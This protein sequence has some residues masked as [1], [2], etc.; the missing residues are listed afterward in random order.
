MNLLG[1]PTVEFCEK[2]GL[3]LIKRPFYALSNLAYLFVGLLILN[4][5]KGSLS[6]KA[7]GYSAIFIGLASFVYDASYTYIS[8]LVDLLGMFLFVHLIIYFSAKRY[9]SITNI[10]LISLQ[11]S[12]VVLGVL[13]IIY[14]KSFTGEFV[15]GVYIILAM[16]LEF[17]L[18]RRGEANNIKLWLKGVA[19][20]IIGFIIWLPD[21]SGLIC[22]PNNYI[23]GRSIFHILTS[24][25]IFVL[26]KYYS[27][28]E[29]E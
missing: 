17:L 9:F 2:A 18:W 1:A 3:G 23:N 19:L 10:K 22:D 4:K 13:S 8:Q 29:N 26:Y 21:A 7:F 11:V 28:Q 6:S 24:M 15:F 5:G 16:F 27:L 12:S 20:F 25:T 14:F